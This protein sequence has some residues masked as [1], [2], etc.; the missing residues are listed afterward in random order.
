MHGTAAQLHSTPAQP[1]ACPRAHRP[2]DDPHARMTLR[3]CCWGAHK[4][5]YAT[6]ARQGATGVVRFTWQLLSFTGAHT[7][8]NRYKHTH[9]QREPIPPL[10]GVLCTSGRGAMQTRPLSWVVCSHARTPHHTTTHADICTQSLLRRH[11]QPASPTPTHRPPRQQQSTTSATHTAAMQVR[12]GLPAGGCTQTHTH[13][14]RGSVNEYKQPPHPHTPRAQSRHTH[15]HQKCPGGTCLVS[16]A[17][18][19]ST[20][21]GAVCM[22]TR[23]G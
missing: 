16:A 4:K 18:R 15:L 23:C 3:G 22:Y 17:A 6:A 19:D 14:H 8:T 1:T 5:K 12:P 11:R 2:P 7:G 10:C 13:T 20:Q 9:R 21:Q